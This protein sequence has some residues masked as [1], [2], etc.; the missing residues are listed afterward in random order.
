MEVG[1]LKEAWVIRCNETNNAYLCFNSPKS[2]LNC[3]FGQQDQPNVNCIYFATKEDAEH[4]LNH[5]LKVNKN[6]IKVNNRKF[7]TIVK[8]SMDLDITDYRL[9]E[10]IK[11]LK[12]LSPFYKLSSA[13]YN[14]VYVSKKYFDEF[15][16]AEGKIDTI[17]P[18][19]PYIVKVNVMSNLYLVPANGNTKNLVNLQQGKL[20]NAIIFNTKDDA[21]YVRNMYA[22]NKMCASNIKYTSVEQYVE[23]NTVT[24]YN[25]ILTE[26]NKIGYVHK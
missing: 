25:I 4:A 20:E 2:T 9:K 1:N 11:S 21:E 12:E 8:F 17:R 13:Y 6:K 3:V 5:Y 24:K 10:P 15:L 23:N 7:Y 26:Y 19:D 16:K 18:I 14:D 22:T